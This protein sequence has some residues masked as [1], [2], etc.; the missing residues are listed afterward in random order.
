MSGGDS[1][2][3]ITS[4][5][6]YR[7][8]VRQNKQRVGRTQSNC[9]LM[10]PAFAQPAL[11]GR[12]AF[13]QHEDGLLV[14]VDEGRYATLYYYWRRGA[15]LP[16]LHDADTLVVED[17]AAY[18]DEH[19]AFLAG[20]GLQL[21]HTNVQY[22]LE[23]PAATQDAPLAEGYRLVRCEDEGLAREVVRLWERRLE[24]ADVPLDH[25]RFLELDDA[26]WCAMDAHDALAGAIWW[27]DQGTT[28]NM[29]HIVVDERH[30]RRGLAR[31]LL[32]RCATD[33]TQTGMLRVSTWI[34]DK[35]AASIALH[36]CMGYSATPRVVRQFIASEE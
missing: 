20:A 9:M 4:V 21:A 33:A 15:A 31:A 1:V 35:N 34:C 11:E 18:T 7:S 30:E 14:R 22:V 17:S 26:V 8:L 27:Q 25:T 28:R 16:R 29:R 2:E 13:E 24:V 10:A 12:L 6:Q 5:D 19:R 23:L 36:E 32:Q 3:P